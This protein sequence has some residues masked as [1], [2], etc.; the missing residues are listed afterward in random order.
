MSKESARKHKT[1]VFV[2]QD[3]DPPPEPKD[4]PVLIHLRLLDQRDATAK[5]CL[6]CYLFGFCLFVF[7]CSQKTQ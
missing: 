2:E 6:P 7:A 3:G 1:N 4:V 5:V